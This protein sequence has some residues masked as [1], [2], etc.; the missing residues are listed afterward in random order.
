[1]CPLCSSRT[2]QSNATTDLG[3]G[4][5]QGLEDGLALGAVLHGAS[6][7][8]EIE[9]RL[10]IYHRVRHK[11]ASVIQILSNV[12]QEQSHLVHDELRQYLAENEIP[13]T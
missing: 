13:S 4:G 2:V 6:T 10:D 7:P 12:G 9:A 1:M 8:A 3:Q 11:R 5:A